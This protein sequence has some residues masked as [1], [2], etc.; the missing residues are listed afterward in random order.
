LPLYELALTTAREC[1][2]SAPDAEVTLITPEAEPLEIF[3]SAAS[4]AMRTLLDAHGITLL[5]GS[6]GVPSRP[7]R[8]H[9]APGGRRMDVDRVVTLPR[10]AGP[11][12]R[13]MPLGRDGFIPTDLHGRV[14][15]VDDVYAAGDATSFP[16]K[17]GGLAAQQADAAA[18]AIAASLGADITPRPFTPV[19]RGL[20]LTG[21]SR[22]YLRADISAGAGDSTVSDEALWWP[23]NRLCGRYLAP[24]L[25]RQVGFAADVMPR[26]EHPIPVTI[27]IE[28]QP[29]DTQRRFVELTDVDPS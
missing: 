13:G 29:P 19:L 9:L 15:G 11:L 23:P 22:R 18:E 4:H 2:A 6:Y 21:G 3:G 14:P 10:L 26:D 12:L 1:A 17:Q 27:A 16:I 24:Y 28:P 7:G 5:T 20:L 25:S 8:L